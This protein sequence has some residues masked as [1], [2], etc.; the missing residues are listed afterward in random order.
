MFTLTIA[1]K[2]IQE[3]Q[4]Y[5]STQ[6]VVNT[7]APLAPVPS[8]VVAAPPATA[9][10]VITG[11]A[12]ASAPSPIAPPPVQVLAPAPE[13]ATSSDPALLDKNGHTW[14]GRIH[15]SSKAF[16][17]D[18]T[19]RM[20]RGVDPDLVRQIQGASPTSAPAP[21][22]VNPFAAVAPSPVAA[23]VLAPSPVGQAAMTM[24]AKAGLSPYT[25]IVVDTSK[26]VNEGRITYAEILSACQQLGFANLQ[27]LE[28]NEEMCSAFRML[29]TGKL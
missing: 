6:G 20:K 24:P 26:A 19:W 12:P 2:T 22:A 3:L 11:L 16:V 5:L 7:P 21:A 10:E 25:Q 4:Q 15:A 9:P 8:T 1:F 13:A 18:G 27:G 29:L 28:G 23:P 14:D 17:A